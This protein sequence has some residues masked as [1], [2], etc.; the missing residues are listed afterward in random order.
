[1]PVRT[2]MQTA[3]VYPA[4][5]DNPQ[6]SRIGARGMEYLM[7]FYHICTK[8]NSYARW[9]AGMVR[10]RLRIFVGHATCSARLSG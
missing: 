7:I 2:G 9:C 1:M 10:K 4:I 5:N 8:N 3:A 6:I